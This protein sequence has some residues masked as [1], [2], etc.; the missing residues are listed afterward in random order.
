MVIGRLDTKGLFILPFLMTD[1]G[2]LGVT[3]GVCHECEG[4][5]FKS[6]DG[7]PAWSPGGTKIA[8]TGVRVDS[9]LIHPS[10]C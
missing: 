7:I 5:Q 9:L 4:F 3:L 2:I 8:F 10:K 1:F 6:W